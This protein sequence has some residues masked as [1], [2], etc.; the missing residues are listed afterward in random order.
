[1]G[2]FSNPWDDN[3][4]QE[5]ENQGPTAKENPFADTFTTDPL[6][7]LSTKE[8]S[9][10]LRSFPMGSKSRTLVQTCVD[11]ERRRSDGPSTPG[12]PAFGFSGVGGRK[13][14]PSKWDDA[15]KWV[16][17]ASYHDFPSYLSEE[18]DPVRMQKQSD[19]L[20]KSKTSH[21]V[22]SDVF[23]E[24]KFTEK[25]EPIILGFEENLLFTKTDHSVHRRDS[26]T[27]V[28]PYGSVTTS[29]CHTPT[30]ISSPARHN[31]PADRSGVLVPPK[32][33]ID[34]SELNDCHFDL[35][36]PFDTAMGG[37]WTSKEDEISKDLCHFERLE[38]EDNGRRNSFAESRTS[39]WEDDEKSKSYMRYQREEAKI[40]AL[41]NLQYAKA[42]AQSR[43][44][45]MKIQKLISN[46]EEKVMKRMASVQ[47]RAEQ[48]R[49][50]AQLQH[51]QEIRRVEEEAEKIRKKKKTT[52]T[53]QQ[54]QH[55]FHLF[56]TT[57]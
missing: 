16:I 41:L 37:N 21:E 35:S 24:D 27:Q 13:S 5:S 28:T 10:L 20:F 15:D 42:E 12:R 26:T 38:V 2:L 36:A 31:T 49:T 30:K 54:R 32:P 52:T 47:R 6:C 39:A 34:L 4:I 23:L 56:H 8:A 18:T 51:T 46:L 55:P 33:S 19:V 17:S 40:E 44:L 7:K 14:I 57:K 53:T 9:E 11:G 3:H 29:R 50:A 48:W 45:E 25:A 43:K 22:S 1:M